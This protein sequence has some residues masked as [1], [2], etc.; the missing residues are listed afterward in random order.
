MC[1]VSPLCTLN[2]IET[3]WCSPLQPVCTIC[4]FFFPINI[5][6]LVLLAAP[7]T[8]TSAGSSRSYIRSS[9]I[10]SPVKPSHA[11]SPTKPR[12]DFVKALLAANDE[13]VIF[14]CSQENQFLTFCDAVS[15]YDARE[16]GFNFTSDFDILDS[17]PR[18]QGEIPLGSFVVVAYTMS[19]YVK[20]KKGEK[21][22]AEDPNRDWH[23]SMNIQFAILFATP[24]Q[25][26]VQLF[27]IVYSSYYVFNEY[28]AA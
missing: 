4:Y 25:T 1:L 7:D 8:Q 13:G 6:T 24:E 17:L 21:S 16:R 15:V 28:L 19:S 2:L 9:S 10:R 18:F 14:S 27:I 3:C 11:R 22:K 12:S 20:Y 23:L 26:P 5:L